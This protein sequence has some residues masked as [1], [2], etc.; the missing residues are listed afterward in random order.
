VVNE[1]KV[2]MFWTEWS[3]CDGCGGNGERKRLAG[4]ALK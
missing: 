3:A 2:G 1:Y 4:I